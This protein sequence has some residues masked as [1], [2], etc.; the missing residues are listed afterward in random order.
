MTPV[1]SAT[2]CFS[3]NSKTGRVPDGGAVA[4]LLSSV[5]SSIFCDKYRSRCDDRMRASSLHGVQFDGIII[6]SGSCWRNV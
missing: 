2:H 5:D 4:L 3:G 1:H 6:S